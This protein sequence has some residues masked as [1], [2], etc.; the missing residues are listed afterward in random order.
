[1]HGER[2]CADK[3][4]GD[5]VLQDMG[6]MLGIEEKVQVVVPPVTQKIRKGSRG[7]VG[8]SQTV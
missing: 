2:D 4:A 5:C 1:M 6:P 8:S 3:H 7:L